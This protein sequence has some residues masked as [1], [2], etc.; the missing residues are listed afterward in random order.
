MARNHAGF[1]EIGPDTRQVF[2]F[3]AKQIYPLTAGDFD[4][5]YVN[6]LMELVQKIADEL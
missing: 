6:R 1:V 3:D 2:L 5:G 4:V